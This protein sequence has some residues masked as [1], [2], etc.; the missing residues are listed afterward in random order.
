MNFLNNCYYDPIGKRYPITL[1]NLKQSYPRTSF[2]LVINDDFLTFLGL[3]KVVFVKKPD[4]DYLTHELVEGTPVKNGQY[5]YQNWVATSL[6][7][8][9][10]QQQDRLTVLKNEKLAEL[11]AYRYNIEVS[12]ITIGSSQIK[13]DRESQAQLASA[14]LTVN[15]GFANVINW[16]S[17]NG[18]TTLNKAQLQHIGKIVSQHVQGCFNVEQMHA[19]NISKCDTAEA[20]GAYDFKL[21]W[22]T[23]TY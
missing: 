14:L 8:T 1:E 7:L 9:S 5:Y 18:W 20:L 22:P 11:S 21:G 12:G 17:E 15:E 16:K 6:N 2:P 19:Q 23:T 10:E 3:V 4:V 13:T